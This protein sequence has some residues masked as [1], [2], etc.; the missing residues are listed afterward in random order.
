[1]SNLGVLGMHLDGSGRA[2]LK[3]LE[4]ILAPM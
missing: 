1:M 4:G 2:A 3:V